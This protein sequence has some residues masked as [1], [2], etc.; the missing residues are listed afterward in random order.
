MILRE[1]NR[2]FRGKVAAWLAAWL[3]MQGEDFPLVSEAFGQAAR[4]M[5]E[6]LVGKS[7][8][9]TFVFA[10]QH[11]MQRIVEVIAPLRVI[12]VCAAAAALKQVRLIGFI[13]Q[14]EMAVTAS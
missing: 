9:I 13:F 7:S 8:V 1:K 2:R 4:E 12:K 10:R 3:V 14:H 6:G 11:H 5:R